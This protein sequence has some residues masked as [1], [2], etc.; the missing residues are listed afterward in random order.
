MLQHRLGRCFQMSDDG[1]SEKDIESIDTLAEIVRQGKHEI[2]TQKAVLTT[3]G[4]FDRPGLEKLI[5]LHRSQEDVDMRFSGVFAKINLFGN[6]IDLGPVIQH[7]HGKIDFLPDDIDDLIRRAPVETSLPRPTSIW[8]FRVLIAPNYS[9]PST[10]S[11]RKVIS[12]SIL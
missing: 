3:T 7:I 5:D 6:S 9:M 10:S 2:V 12:R 4:I 8:L 1:P 11:R